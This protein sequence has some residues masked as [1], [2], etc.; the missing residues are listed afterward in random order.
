VLANFLP[1]FKLFRIKGTKAYQSFVPFMVQNHQVQNPI[2][3]I[4]TFALQAD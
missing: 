3:K 1:K 4:P 2:L